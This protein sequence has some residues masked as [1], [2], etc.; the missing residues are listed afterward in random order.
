MRRRCIGSIV[1]LIVALSVATPVQADQAYL[2]DGTDSFTVG[3]RDVRGAVVY[4]GR[5]NLTAA[6]DGERTRF[7]S[8][9]DYSRSEQ[10]TRSRGHSTFASVVGPAGEPEDESGGDPDYVSVLN[11]PFAIVLDAPT[12]RDLA[13]LTAP[14]ALSFVLP[15][16]GEPLTGTLRR[17]PDAFVAG[18]RVLQVVFAAQG[19]VHG[20]IGRS[21]VA[22][23][24]R[25]AMRGTA[26][27]SY[28]S[29]LLL[30]LD[31]RLAI[32][33]KLHGEAARRSV[34]IVYGRRIRAVASPPLKEAAH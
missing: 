7:E 22:V 21:G 4:A 11:Q 9:V 16:T 2:V 34:T 15:L 10:G 26:Y 14:V 1:S 20:P 24:G 27:Y 29:A 25:I 18:E 8:T 3:A 19:P 30:A 23:D 31:T 6:R 13:R 33:G 28:A 32:S 12:M 17:G 5:E